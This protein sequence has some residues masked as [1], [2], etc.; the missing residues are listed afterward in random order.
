MATTRIAQSWIEESYPPE[1]EKT[2]WLSII[3][4]FLLHSPCRY[5]SNQRYPLEKKWGTSP[6]LIPRFLKNPLNLAVFGSKDCNFIKV[7]RKKDLNDKLAALGL[8]YNF[9]SQIKTSVAAFTEST[10]NGNSSVY[11]SLFYHLRNALAHARF[12]FTKNNAGNLV[13]LFEDGTADYKTGD[14]ELSARGAIEIRA[15]QSIITIIE[16]GPDC[17]PDIENQILAAIENGITTKKRI[18]D[19]LGIGSDDWN[20][21]SQVLRKEG[22]ISYDQR[23]KHWSLVNIQKE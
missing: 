5:Q 16:N 1:L 8:A 7:K 22:K 2:G 18:K 6:W 9:P 4:F 15:L 21:Y 13:L 12:G 19:E 17:L 23:K 10:G 11:M 3:D 20:T 14:F